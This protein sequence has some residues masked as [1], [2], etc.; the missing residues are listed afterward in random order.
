MQPQTGLREPPRRRPASTVLPWRRGATLAGLSWAAFALFAQQ[1]GLNQLSAL[2]REQGWV[3]LFDGKTTQGWR[4]FRSVAVPKCWNVQDDA[5]HLEVPPADHGGHDLI[6]QKTYENFDLQWDWKL[7]SKGN[8]GLKYFVS[9]QRRTPLG[10][11][12][13]MLDDLNYH[14]SQEGD[15]SADFRNTK[16]GTA[17]FYDVLAPSGV[18]LRPI[19]QYN[20]SRVLVSGNH[21]EHWLN[22]RKV[23]EYELGSP[24]V[25]EAV[26]HSKF[27]TVPGFGQ[28][29]AG[30]LLL[31]DHGDEVWFRNIKI[32]VL[33]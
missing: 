12:Y 8:S 21:V 6:S 1:A 15:H 20:H 28:R 4:S 11:E 14:L 31:Q 24:A 5:L 18:E 30:H 10:H 17:A 16:H 27:K 33:P 22:G 26:A 9:D 29:L 2:E 32:R 3:L 23:L 7:A 25:L 13:Q 19:G